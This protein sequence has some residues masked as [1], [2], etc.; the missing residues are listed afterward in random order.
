MPDQLIPLY[1]QLLERDLLWLDVV[2][3]ACLLYTSRCV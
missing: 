1:R 3:Y 2:G